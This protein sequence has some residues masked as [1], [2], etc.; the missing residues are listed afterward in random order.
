MQNLATLNI[1]D[2]LSQLAG[3]LLLLGIL[4][5]LVYLGGYALFLW[6]KWKDREKASLD[7][8]LLQ[9]S[10][11]RDNE[12][13]IDAA[14]QLFAGFAS[15]RKSGRFAALHPQPHITFELVGKPGD[16]RYYIHVPKKLRDLVEKQINGAYPDAD[17]SVVDENDVKQKG[18]IGNE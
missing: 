16:I 7:S 6:Y 13:K 11:P 8:V 12:I 5:G 2:V 1:F 18:V 3:S 9:V 17:I 14:E 15:L 4:A 10:L